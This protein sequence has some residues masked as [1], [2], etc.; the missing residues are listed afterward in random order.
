M[1]DTSVDQRRLLLIDG[2]SM[3]YRA[4]YALPK[5]NFA[6]QTGQHTNAVYGFTSMLINLLRDEKPTHI[7]VA[8]DV[9]RKTFRS[10]KFAAYKA[11]RSSAPDEFKGQVSLIEE[12]LR[13]LCIPWLSKDNYEADDL[14][15]TLTTQAV[16]DGFEVLI[17]SGDRDVIQ[18]VNDQVTLL[19]PSRGVSEM[20]RLDPAMVLTKYGVTPTQYPDFAALRGDPSDNLP[21]IPGVGAK[22][23]TK[24]I[25]EVGFL[26][27]TVDSVDEVKVKAWAA[28]RANQSN[29]ML[30]RH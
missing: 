6:T 5:E 16:A 25:Q 20:W 9:S 29:V 21:N 23:I 3:A 18:L 1:L 4:F 14:I 2:H 27:Q 26:N 15:A 13:A 17:C 8:F 19:Y 11:T 12:V 28:L 30:N 24:W 22:T 7:A 10:E